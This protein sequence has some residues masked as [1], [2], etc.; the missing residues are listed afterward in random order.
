MA[1]RQASQERERVAVE[2][3]GAAPQR[4]DPALLTAAAGATA[5]PSGM[6]QDSWTRRLDD[7]VL[8]PTGVLIVL[9]V[10]TACFLVAAVLSALDRSWVPTIVYGGLAV[11]A[12]Q[13][14]RVQRRS[15]ANRVSAGRP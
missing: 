9:A 15:R 13:A 10:A 14:T 12:L 7:R 1:G 2:R 3:V 8:G 4:G 5:Y 6:K 11:L